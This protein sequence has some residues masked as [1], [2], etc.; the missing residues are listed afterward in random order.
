MIGG[1][2]VVYDKDTLLPR[3]HSFH[4]VV[5]A[6]TQRALGRVY[7]FTDVRVS[8]H[9]HDAQITTDQLVATDRC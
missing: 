2:N 4:K 5:G 9:I 1:W 3:R 6:C 7:V 8:G